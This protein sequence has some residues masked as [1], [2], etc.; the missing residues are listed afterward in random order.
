MRR[1]LWGIAVIGIWMAVPGI[2]CESTQ[3]VDGYEWTFHRMDDGNRYHEIRN[4]G[5]YTEGSTLNLTAPCMGANVDTVQ[6]DWE[7]NRS[8]VRGELVV[9]PGDKRLGVRDISGNNRASWAVQS[10]MNRFRIEFSGKR[11]H[12]CRIRFIR[13][14]YGRN[15]QLGGVQGGQVQ[16][17]GINAGQNTVNL[18]DKI[19]IQGGPVLRKARVMRWDGNQLHVVLREGNRQRNQALNPGQISNLIFADRWGKA[20][21]K[22]GSRFPVRIHSMNG[23]MIDFDK[24]LNGNVVPKGTTDIHNF[25]SITFD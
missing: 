3:Y 13:V 5:E 6:V 23:S 17:Q 14:F 1:V 11:G 4:V 9:M 16:G 7:D 20:V 21:A 15:G 18:V 25:T 19:T 8:E 12:R 22:D 24:R 10:N 2:A